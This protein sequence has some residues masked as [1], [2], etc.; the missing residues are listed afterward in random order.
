MLPFAQ[1][2]GAGRQQLVAQ[3]V[4]VLG[5]QAGDGLVALE[6]KRNQLGLTGKGLPA[7]SS[8][9]RLV[10]LLVCFQ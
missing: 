10:Q 1:I 9:Y 8:I 4:V 7:V 3:A 2:V 5:Q 6:Q